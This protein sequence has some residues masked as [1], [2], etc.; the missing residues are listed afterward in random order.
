VFIKIDTMRPLT[1]GIVPSEGSDD[2]RKARG[3]QRNE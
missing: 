3:T 2:H 1:A